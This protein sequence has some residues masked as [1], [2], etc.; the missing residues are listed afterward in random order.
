MVKKLKGKGVMKAEDTSLEEY[1]T[2]FTP[3]KIILFDNRGP[4][5][6]LVHW[7]WGP[8]GDVRLPVTVRHP[9]HSVGLSQSRTPHFLPPPAMKAPGFWLSDT[10]PEGVIVH[11][12]DWS[13]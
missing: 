1:S 10:P 4:V 8:S 2:I 3:P 7:V 5:H 12:S 9:S 11:Q 13:F 6:E